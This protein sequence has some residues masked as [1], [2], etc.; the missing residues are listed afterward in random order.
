MTMLRL[1]CILALA[2]S[3]CTATIGVRPLERVEF[4]KISD[5]EVVRVSD[6][7][8]GRFKVR[9]THHFASSTFSPISIEAASGRSIAGIPEGS[10]ESVKW[11]S[12]EDFLII[13][14]GGL[15]KRLAES[16]ASYNQYDAVDLE[17]GK[18][19]DL[20]KMP[21]LEFAKYFKPFAEVLKRDRFE[22][23]IDSRLIAVESETKTAVIS[24][25]SLNFNCVYL[26]SLKDGSVLDRNLAGAPLAQLEKRLDGNSERIN[27]S[28]LIMEG[29][30]AE[31]REIFSPQG[32]R[33]W[34]DLYYRM[35][36]EEPN[37]LKTRVF[38]DEAG[39]RVVQLS[40][41]ESK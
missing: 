14:R 37:Q 22:D 6:S 25:H 10:L 26:V 3:V 24:V 13:W 20:I 8:S 38:T 2:S 11:T 35:K 36:F 41:T 4:K 21:Q 40:G 9:Q 27:R 30:I 33:I 1:L 18:V 12:R 16:F 23:F 19:I 34:I 32:K 39:I 15:M 31:M 7:P 28:G 5:A 29:G 17:R